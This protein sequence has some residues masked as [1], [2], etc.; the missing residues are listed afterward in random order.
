MNVNIYHLSI[1]TGL[2][3]VI[4]WKLTQPGTGFLLFMIVGA[5]IPFVFAFGFGSMTSSAGGR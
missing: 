1:M 2:L 3:A 4:P 5:L